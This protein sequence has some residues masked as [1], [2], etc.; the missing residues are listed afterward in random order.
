MKER[1]DIN[2]VPQ[3][4]TRSNWPYLFIYARACGIHVNTKSTDL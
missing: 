1:E 4:I 3:N 2:W